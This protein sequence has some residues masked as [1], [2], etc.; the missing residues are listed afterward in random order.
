M[1]DIGEDGEEEEVEGEEEEDDG[2]EEEED[3]EET[4]LSFS[5]CLPFLRFC[6]GCWCSDSTWAPAPPS[7]FR[8]PSPFLEA[9]RELD[10]AAHLL[11][12]LD[13]CCCCC[14]SCSNLCCSNSRVFSSSSF[15]AFS[16]ACNKVPHIINNNNKPT[17]ICKQ[18]STH[19]NKKS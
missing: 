5:L 1:T 10:S 11:F 19:S 16:S 17:S 6:G 18:T 2:D 7:T 8:P 12:L 9:A 3:D 13:C 15:L 4:A 14:L